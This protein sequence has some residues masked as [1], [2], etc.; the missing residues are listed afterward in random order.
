[1]NDAYNNALDQMERN[2]TLQWDYLEEEREDDLPEEDLD[3]PLTDNQ[4]QW[5]YDNC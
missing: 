1:M 4:R 2:R 3:V 5:I